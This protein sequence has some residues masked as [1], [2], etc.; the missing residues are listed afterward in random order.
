MVA[1]SKRKTLY[2]A[3]PY[4]YCKRSASNEGEYYDQHGVKNRVASG[5]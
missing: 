4:P 5:D 2:P 3:R 1:R